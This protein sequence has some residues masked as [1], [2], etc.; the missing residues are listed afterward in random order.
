MILVA[1]IIL[2]ASSRYKSKAT[3]FF[4]IALGTLLFSCRVKIYWAKMFLKLSEATTSL[5]LEQ[6]T[7]G[8]V[9]NNTIFFWYQCNKEVI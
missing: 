5:F 9:K 7:G 4:K 3:M 6:L 2:S 1:N 8:E